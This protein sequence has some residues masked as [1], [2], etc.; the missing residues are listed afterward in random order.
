MRHAALPPPLS[1]KLDAWAA[2]YGSATAPAKDFTPFAGTI[3]RLTEAAVERRRILMRYHALNSG[4]VTER[5]FDA[6]AV[7]F[8]PD[9]ATLKVIG[10]DHHRGR[11]T[12]F[13]IDHIQDL[14]PTQRRF[15]RQT[16][17]L[18]DHLD[19]INH[20]TTLASRQM[21]EAGRRASALDLV[22]HPPAA[23]LRN[24][25]L[26]RGF[27]DGAAGLTISLM[28]TYAVFL[29]FAKLW[30]L[31]R[32]GAGAAQAAAPQRPGPTP[33]PAESPKPKAVL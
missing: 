3:D 17:D 13:A 8:D 7:Y 19:R 14:Q 10:W 31:Q 5:K 18:R 1:E 26:R 23:F 29:K 28:N 30:E 24:Y 9:G 11:F 16:F 22:V 4:E 27:M 20:Y 25:V 32:L 12:P 33:P 21:H 2:V 6:Y 15:V